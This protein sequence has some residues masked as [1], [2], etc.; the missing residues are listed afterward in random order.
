M[1]GTRLL[2]SIVFAF[3]GCIT[4]LQAQEV[5]PSFSTPANQYLYFDQNFNVVQR[6]RTRKEPGKSLGWGHNL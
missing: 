4:I 3:F 2:S 1:P 5:T 6:P